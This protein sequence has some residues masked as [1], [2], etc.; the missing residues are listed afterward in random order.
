M[1]E[2]ISKNITRVFSENLIMSINYN[3]TFSKKG[4]SSFTAL[5]NAMFGEYLLAVI[6]DIF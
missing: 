3:G 5:N 4:L 1:P 2:G 6:K